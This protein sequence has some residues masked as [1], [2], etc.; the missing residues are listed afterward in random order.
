LVFIP[1]TKFVDG[2]IRDNL[3]GAVFNVMEKHP[4]FLD[5]GSIHSSFD[6]NTYWSTLA[7]IHT[8]ADAYKVSSIYFIDT[9]QE[10]YRFL[11]DC[12]DSE[13]VFASQAERK[14]V[15]SVYKNV[16]AD[17]QQALDLGTRVIS[18]KPY[19]DEYGTFMSVFEPV[20]TDTGDII[21][22]LG[23]D[24]EIGAIQALRQQM[25]FVF[26]VPIGLSII[27]AVFL[28]FSVSVSLIRPLQDIKKTTGELA[29]LRVPEPFVEAAKKE[30][31]IPAGNRELDEIARDLI[32]VQ[33]LLQIG[34]PYI[35]EKIKQEKV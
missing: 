24:K 17:I 22:I 27:A 19:I 12:M 9:R 16:A 32:S 15:M 26:L 8:V 25:I 35:L 31:R 21:G 11:W 23:A 14:E 20:I 3:E 4:S 13:T 33:K 18:S 30:T 10:P 28:C 7:S 34:R 5:P 29:G 2:S 1:L 6:E